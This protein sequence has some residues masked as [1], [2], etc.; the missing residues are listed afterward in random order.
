MEPTWIPETKRIRVLTG[1]T[2]C[3][4]CSAVKPR[5]R[6]FCYHHPIQIKRR[7]KKPGARRIKRGQ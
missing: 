1:R 3:D 4:C 5:H 2:I 7:A 6:D